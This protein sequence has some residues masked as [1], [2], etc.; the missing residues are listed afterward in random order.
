M[1]G[2]P[3]PVAEVRLQG[4]GV[5]PGIARGVAL[6]HAPDDDEAP[7]YAIREEDLPAEIARL[8]NALAA[9]RVQISE[10]QQRIADAIGAKDAGIFDAHLLVVEDQTLIDEVLRLVREQLRNIEHV[11]QQV[12]NGYARTLSE[13]DDPYLRE[14]ALDIHDVTRRVLRNL[15]GKSPR[16][17]ATAEH[18][19]LLVAADLTPSD[20][21]QMNRALVLGFATDAGSRT[22]HTAIMARSLDLP[23]VVGLHHATE[24][25]TTGD[26]L[27]ID[28]Y[29]GL[30]FIRP[31]ERTLY[32]YGEIETRKTRVEE[33]LTH[34][35]DTASNT[36]DGRHIILSANI[37]LPEDVGNVLACGAE[38]IGLYR[39]EFFFLNQ[40][41][42][43][44]EEEQYQNYVQIASAVRPHKVIIRTLDIG[45]DKIVPGMG[46][47]EER[48]PF[49][50]WR[51]IRF[52]LERTDLF[53]QQL[54]AILRASAGGGVRLMYPMISS[55]GEL[56]RANAVLEECRVELRAESIPFAEDLEV[57]A[58]IEVPSA[59][60]TADLLA[61]EVDF[62]SIG[63]NDLIQ[64]TIAVDRL[65][66]RI[67]HL[68]EP[69]HP[70]ILRMIRGIVDAAHAR[71][72]WVG[73]CGET[74]GEV[75]LT[76]LLIGLG[77]DE[78]SVGAAV[79]PSVKRAI[80]SLSTEE[81]RALAEES[82]RDNDPSSIL[83]RCTAHARERYPELFE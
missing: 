7:S 81:C 31:S 6:V 80:Q 5:A 52:C 67:A 51:A 48:N 65:N 70:A 34:L 58:M 63:T 2:E 10:S 14:R 77:V 45:G 36:R 64:Y 26:S 30:V 41:S 83:Q 40:T 76:P 54:R 49:L 19:H 79:V 61:D 56:R 9:T 23:A 38:G 53:K 72:K 35:R 69:T 15:L 57:G 16:T 71:G 22:S 55:L 33:Q 13:I 47:P 11:Y 60:I 68:Y 4:I 12:A 18:P 27:L 21:A 42:L 75:T 20:T 46:E 8:K 24:L 37:E 59:A 29:S 39:T 3:D 17:L 50:G 1:S 73:V 62:F 74:A 78:L 44:D 28:G 66:E 32:E 25:I 82:L 43:P